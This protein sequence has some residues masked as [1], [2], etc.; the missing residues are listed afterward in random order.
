MFLPCF[1]QLE[2]ES[3]SAE[4]FPSVRESLSSA[5]FLAGKTSCL[6]SSACRFGPYESLRAFPLCG[7]NILRGPRMAIGGIR[8]RPIRALSCP[9]AKQLSQAGNR[10]GRTHGIDFG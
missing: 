8:D 5:L 4:R 3:A 2:R 1:P 10:S 9:H 6:G 7:S